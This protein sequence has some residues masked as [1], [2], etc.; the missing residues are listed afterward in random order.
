MLTMTRPKKLHPDDLV[1][2]EAAKAKMYCP[3]CAA[4]PGEPCIGEHEKARKHLHSTRIFRYEQYR[5]A[6]APA[7]SFAPRTWCMV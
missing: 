3:T 7:K 1:L 6:D 5:M 2:E 4:E